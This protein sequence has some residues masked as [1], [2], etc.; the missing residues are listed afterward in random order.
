MITFLKKLKTLI[1]YRL[2]EL[3]LAHEI[4]PD[5]EIFRMIVL[6]R[7]ILNDVNYLIDSNSHL[8]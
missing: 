3:T 2:A 5:R 4:K 8:K 1:E 6:N 7:Q